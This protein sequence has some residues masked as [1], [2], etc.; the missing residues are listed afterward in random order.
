MGNG[1]DRDPLFVLSFMLIQHFKF[2]WVGPVLNRWSMVISLDFLLYFPVYLRCSG[3]FGLEPLKRDANQKVKTRKYSPSCQTQGTKAL[4]YT[5]ENVDSLWTPCRF[6]VAHSEDKCFVGSW[7]F[8][9]SP[10][11]VCLILLS[12]LILI[13]SLF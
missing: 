8:A 1:N 7:I 5:S 2:S 12:L 9:R 13:S 11:H 3:S 10:L 4:N 6:A